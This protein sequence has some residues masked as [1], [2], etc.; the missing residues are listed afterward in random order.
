MQEAINSHNEPVTSSYGGL[1]SGL[2]YSYS[3]L[4][5]T[6]YPSAS[7]SSQSYGGYGSSSLG[8]YSAFR[9][10]GDERLMAN[11]YVWTNFFPINSD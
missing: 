9:L 11:S 10:W 1:D 5:S 3:Q 4:G 6:S 2:R 7:F 8:G